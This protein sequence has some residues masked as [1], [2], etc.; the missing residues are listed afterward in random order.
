MAPNQ[1]T[2][3]QKSRSLQE[4]FSS[5]IDT[6]VILIDGAGLAELL[7]DHGVGVTKGDVYV[8]KRIDIDYS[9]E[10]NE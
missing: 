8:M 4:L 10:T 7:I 5:R 6:K 2:V 3:G 1:E 9:Q